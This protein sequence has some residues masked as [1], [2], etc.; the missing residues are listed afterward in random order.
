MIEQTIQSAHFAESDQARSIPAYFEEQVRK[1][2]ER[3]AIK[4]SRGE[5]NFAQLN[6]AANGIANSILAHSNAS[7]HAVALMLDDVG[8]A[9]S[10]ILGALKSG[11]FYT[12][13]DPAYPPS[14]LA[15]MLQDSLAPI[16]L[17]DSQ[18]FEFARSLAGDHCR[19][20][21]VDLIDPGEAAP[22]PTI[23]VSPDQLAYLMYTSGS[24]GTPKGV[25]HT[26]RNAMHTTWWET[27]EMQIQA[28][29]R[30]GLVLSLSYG[31]SINVILNALLNGGRLCSYSIAANGLGGLTE[32]LL[33][34][35]ITVLKM[36]PSLFRQFAAQLED[37]KE[38]PNLR[39]IMF[40]GEP[41]LRRDVEA[42]R[43]CFSDHCRLRTTL[44][45]TETRAY[46]SFMIDKQTPIEGS[47]VPSGYPVA[48]Y[49]TLLWDEHGNPVED[50]QIGNIIV[51]SRYLARGYWHRP[52]LT[53]RVF[54]P[55]PSGGDE[56]LYRT[57][58][59][60][61]IRPGGLL[62][63]LGRKDSQ[64]KIRGY[65]VETKEI[66]MALLEFP[67]IRQAAVMARSDGAEDEKRLVAYLATSREP[68]PSVGEVRQFLKQHLPEFMIPTAL[69]FLSELPL[70]PNGKVDQNALP[71]PASSRVRESD[72]ESFIYPRDRF[73]LELV[74]IWEEVLA[75]HPIGVN[76]KFFDLGGHSL[77]AAQMLAQVES[78]YGKQFPPRVLYE[79]ATIAELAVLL[80]DAG[81][82]PEWSAVVPIQ[83]R[84]DRPPLFYFPPL[85]AVLS[86]NGIAARLG[87]DQPVYGLLAT[88]M[89]DHNP[90]TRIED[91]AAFHIQQIR[92]IQPRGPYYLVGWS[93][94][95]KVAYE[96]AQQLT[97]QGE[98]VAF[99][100]MLDIG[101]R[102]NNFQARIGYYYRRALY[103]AGLGLQAQVTRAVSQIRSKKSTPSAVNSM[104]IADVRGNDWRG[105]K[106]R[107]RN[108]IPRPW[109]GRIILFRTREQSPH[110]AL[111]PVKGWGYLAGRGVE[112]H[113]V[114]GD[115]GTLLLKPHVHVLAEKF[116]ASLLRVQ[117][118]NS[119]CP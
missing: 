101:F 93:Y 18:H 38:L 10:A 81:W 78:R 12:P 87:A 115:H 106:Q 92:S 113:E 36:T 46:R 55:D 7:G 56:R 97:S 64:V 37:A 118:E 108:Y 75:V 47:I 58:D 76:E 84:G 111:D 116:N 40:A 34:E 105:D 70:L 14:R 77:L 82:Q 13:L 96:I 23:A 41:L 3:I 4:T 71:M 104:E 109:P 45:S 98:C 85:N 119:T 91:E 88:P 52:D 44:S 69:Y 103:L 25:I 73:E 2:A 110:L 79:A 54:L 11:D 112:V 42:Y 59:L 90:F 63:F 83:P 35:E 48:G 53:E 28:D 5:M 107:S 60:G 32:W 43:R 67:G 31:A 49:E 74:Q 86:F 65:R 8:D 72:N 19:V 62:E 15:F 17:T 114:P 94:G 22:N 29:D 102:L 57:G 50:N 26:H 95:G 66:E 89:G 6:R 30:L 99:L 39:L 9:V 80:R 24:T 27:N 100:A 16:V 20:I 33:R 117:S 68:K 51:K 61:R 1:Y 21:N